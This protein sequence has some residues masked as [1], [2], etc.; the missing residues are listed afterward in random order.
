MSP[1]SAKNSVFAVSLTWQ[2]LFSLNFTNVFSWP[3]EQL[4]KV[5]AQKVSPSTRF[6]KNTIF[7]SEGGTYTVT[8]PVSLCEKNLWLPTVKGGGSVP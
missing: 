2:D 5:L 1:L 6:S 3:V 8:H 4:G 7:G